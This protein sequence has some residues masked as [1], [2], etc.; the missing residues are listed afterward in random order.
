MTVYANIFFTLQSH[1]HRL[2]HYITRSVF[3]M[4]LRLY[5]DEYKTQYC[6][7]YLSDEQHTGA[8]AIRNPFDREIH[9]NS[10]AI[11]RWNAR[12]RRAYFQLATYALIEFLLALQTKQT[13]IFPWG[14][15]QAEVF[16]RQELCIHS[17]FVDLWKWRKHFMLQHNRTYNVGDYRCPL[18]R[19]HQYRWNWLT[20]T[21]L[22]WF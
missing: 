5:F 11:N 18:P 7:A 19:Q 8:Q 3:L 22:K 10:E 21:C 6:A 4:C 15:S 16:F 17:L 13:D 14:L 9:S 2:S 1:F 12:V 20:K